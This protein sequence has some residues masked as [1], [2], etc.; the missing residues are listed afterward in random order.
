MENLTYSEILKCNAELKYSLDGIKEYKISVLSNIIVHQIKEVLEYSLKI[1]NINATVCIGDYD[2]IIQDSTKAADSNV[3]II[4]WE[5]CNLIDGL[6]YKFELFDDKQHDEIVNKIC[7]EIDLTLKNLAASSL[8]LVNKFSSV[9]FPNLSKDQSSFEKLANKLNKHLND[10][11]P[12]NVKLVNLDRV[13]YQIGVH[14]SIDLRYYYSSKALYTIEFFREYLHLVK[15]IIMAAN[16]MAK[17]AIIFDCDN[18]LWKGIL[19]EDGFENI[20]M[21]ASSKSGIIFYEIQSLALALSKQGILIGLCSK[22]NLADVDEVIR[23]HRD[24]LIREEYI[25]IKKIN[26]ADKSTNIRQIAEEL[27]IGLDS[28][29]FVDDSPFE[30]NLIKEQLP[31]VKVL[32]VPEKLYQYPQM[33]RSNLGLFYNLSLTEEDLVKSK[34]YKQQSEREELKSGFSNI[35][36]YLA[37]LELKINIFEDDISLIPRMAQMTQKTNQFNLTTKRYTETDI[38]KYV[39]SHT[40]KV[41][42]WSVSDKFGDN[43][44]TGLCIIKLNDK[45]AE[46]DTFLMSCRIIGRNIEFS[47]MDF[48]IDNLIK[49]DIDSITGKYVQTAKNAQVTDF[50]KKCSYEVLHETKIETTF[51]IETKNYRNKNINYIKLENGNRN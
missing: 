48:I 6:N 11:A 21:S 32:Q 39:N 51:A 49:S 38:G 26:W 37:S 50:Y 9:L 20:D 41:F 33:L 28:V 47:I 1:E 25:T 27:N 34:I 19:G 2:N 4:F 18:T 10:V 36:E 3:I 14:K 46:I 16:G 43:G 15:P 44:I 7:L 24:M 31:E 23:N 29:V 30:I 8:V 22:N 13:F 35:E 40:S 12:K 42:A 17:K 5:L 45:N